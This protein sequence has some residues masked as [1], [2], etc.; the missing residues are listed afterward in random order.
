MRHAPVPIRGLLRISGLHLT[1][2]G[3]ALFSAKEWHGFFIFYILRA[4][5]DLDH[6]PPRTN[7]RT[8]THACPQRQSIHKA[9][10]MMLIRTERS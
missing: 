7:G 5:Y 10:D 1:L 3:V 6:F 9:N 4:I 2:V 8:D